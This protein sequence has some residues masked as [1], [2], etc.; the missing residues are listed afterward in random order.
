[1]TISA[2]MRALAV[3]FPATVRTNEYWLEKHPS[4]VAAAEQKT[5][6]KLWSEKHESSPATAAF[7]TEMKPYLADPFRGT[8]VRRVLGPNETSLSLQL[9]AARDAL[10]ARGISAAEVDLAIVS[11][12]YADQVDVGNA[13]FVAKELGLRGAAWNLESACASSVIGF[14]TACALIRAGECERVLVVAACRYS[15]VLDETDTLSWFLADGAGAFLV[16]RVPEGEGYLAGKTVHT[17]DTCGVFF[18]ELMVDD[19]GAARIRMRA[20]PRA[21]QVLR[22]SSQVHLV[23]C[24]EGAARAAGLSLS[25]VDFF[26][27]NTPTAWFAAFAARALGIDVARTITTYPRFANIGP[28]LMP[29]N[30]HEAASSGKI[31]PGDRVL[32]YAVGSVSSASAVVMRWGEVALGPRPA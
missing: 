3:A 1:M 8:V 9:A 13:A 18:P 14:Q 15:H 24:C 29:T 11:T 21:G 10:A 5:L 23:N 31:R 2:G 17:A 22:E 32:L 25:D 4:M 28:V 12:F 26:I 19:T 20:S 16:E 6:A 27:F 7:D 30:L